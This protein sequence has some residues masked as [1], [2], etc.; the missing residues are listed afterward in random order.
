MV[1]G[2]KTPQPPGK[3][4]E[5]VENERVLCYEPDYTKVRVIY[6]AKI[7]KVDWVEVEKEEV[8]SSPPSSSKKAKKQTKQP[9]LQQQ[10]LVHFQGKKTQKQRTFPNKIQNVKTSANA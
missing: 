3:S 8:L 10:F 9:E 4:N 6:D 1:N 5:F 7:L 2:K